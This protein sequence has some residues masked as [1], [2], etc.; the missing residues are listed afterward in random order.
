MGA[1]LATLAHTEPLTPR[2]GAVSLRSAI[3]KILYTFCKIRG[4]KII[5]GFLSNEPKYIEPL[6]SIF[7]ADK[8]GAIQDGELSRSDGLIWEERYILLLWLSHQMLTPFDLQTISSTTSPGFN[9]TEKTI[10]DLQLPSDLPGVASRVLTLCIPALAATARERAAAASAMVRLCLR[11]DMRKLS[12]IDVLVRWAINCLRTDVEAAMDVHSMLGKLTFLGRLVAAGSRE[13]LDLHLSGIYGLC[14]QILNDERYSLLQSSAL[15]RKMIIKTFR[16]MILLGSQPGQY[17]FDINTVLEEVI[18]TLLELLADGDS[19]VR[20]AA[21]KALSVIAMSLESEMSGEI[22]E[23]I[24]DAFNDDVLIQ[25][26]IRNLGAVNPLRWHGLTLTVGHLLYKRAVSPDQ[27]P[28]IINSLLL[29]LNFEQRS[30]TG[31][32]IGS[33]VRD[34]ANYGLWAL[35]RRYTTAELSK[36]N[37]SELSVFDRGAKQNHSITELMAIELFQSACLDPAG[38][39]RRGSSAALQEFIGRH[40]N[41]ITEGI[42]LVQIVDY[43]AVGLRG[44]A[45]VDVAFQVSQLSRHY[46]DALLDSLVGWRGTAAIDVAARKYAGA[47]IGRILSTRSAEDFMAQIRLLIRYLSGLNSRQIEE[48]QGLMLAVAAVIDK[49]SEKQDVRAIEVEI[50]NLWPSLLYAL[51]LEDR[52]FTFPALRPDLTASAFTRLTCSMSVLSVSGE[53]ASEQT[54]SCD[55]ILDKWLRLFLLCSQRSDESVLELIPEAAEVLNGILPK[56]G[57]SDL[58]VACQSALR[59]M[60]S[61]ATKK[62]GHAL[63]LGS[64]YHDLGENERASVVRL[65]TARCSPPADVDDRVLALRGLNIIVQD[66]RVSSDKTLSSEADHGLLP[67]IIAG[68][69]DYTNNERGDVGSLVRLAALLVVETAWRRRWNDWQLC[70]FDGE[71]DDLKDQLFASVVRLAMERLDKVRVRAAQCLFYRQYAPPGYQVWV[72]YPVESIQ[73]TSTADY[74]ASALNSMSSDTPQWL[75]H[76]ILTGFCSSAGIGSEASLQTCRTALST[77]IKSLPDT[78]DAKK[79]KLSLKDFI[80]DFTHVLRENVADDRVSIPVIEVLVYI[81]DMRLLL[82]LRSEDSKWRSLYVLVSK[83]HYRTTNMQKL[84]LAMD[85]YRGLVLMGNDV[86]ACEKEVKDKIV[87]LLLHPFPKVRLKAAECLWVC[88]EYKELRGVDWTRPTRDL[89]GTVEDLKQTTSA[90]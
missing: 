4:E 73:A 64:L 69:N 77:Y 67:G 66:L 36:V 9:G 14:S 26:S 7:E 43:H 61:S 32:S 2:N 57:R 33:N 8:Q 28:G 82:P 6:L 44:R 10:A 55:R 74:H 41:T 20:H 80:T 52:N 71:S 24:L 11:P 88:T 18:G 45:M 51:Q 23:A 39:I 25:G 79:P 46:A 78:T 42:A 29:A 75:R 87:S 53:R 50:R 70:I 22:I 76:A 40:P 35:S 90:A 31:S 63:A 85:A 12:L 47:S 59:S 34:A 83:F 1:Y 89:K 3:C 65:L 38:N 81:L 60:S 84:F 5:A 27:L 13:A 48:R 68:L 37:I 15:A 56:T 30:A 19:P 86:T 62:T 17:G 49:W 72:H 58:Y 21:S 16:C 54:D